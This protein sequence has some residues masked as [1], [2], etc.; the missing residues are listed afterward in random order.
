MPGTPTSHADVHGIHHAFLKDRIPA[1][2][3]QASPRRQQ[4]LGQ[5]GLQLPAWF[6]EATPA[7]RQALAARHD[8]YRG[9]LNRIE[10]TLGAIEDIAAFAEPL[11]K[12]AIKQ[13]F[14]LEL[15]VKQ[16]YFARKFTTRAHS[17]VSA[18]LDADQASGGANDFYRGFSLLETALANFEPDEE[19]ALPCADCQI[20]TGWGSYT[21]EAMPSFE[22]LADERVAIAPHE[23]AQLCRTLDLG[24]RYQAHI[25]ELVQPADG[26]ARTALEQALEQHDREQL[27]LSL[28]VAELQSAVSPSARSMLEQLLVDPAAATLDGR[29]VTLGALKVFGSVLVGPLLI[30]PQRLRSDRVERLVVYLPNDPQQPLKEYVSSAAFMADLRSRLHSASYRQFFSQFVPVREQG[31]FFRRFNRLYQ[32]AG[33]AD[34]ARDYPLQA[35]APR[36]PLDEFTI[37]D[38]LWARARQA[39]VR[40]ICDDARA[41]AVPTG[42]EDRQARLERVMGFFDAVVS[43]FNLAAFVV[44]GLGPL[45]LTVGAA[46]LCDDAFEGIEAFEQGETQEM[47]AHFSSVALNVAAVGT[48]AKVLPQVRLSSLVDGLQPVTLASG[49]QKLWRDDLR[50]YQASV[51]LPADAQPDAQGLYTHEGQRVLVLEGA[52]YRVSQE[53]VGGGYRIRHPSRA[54][55]YE[56]ALVH[57]GQ[58]TWR[59][60]LEQPLTWQGAL[61]MRRLG[62]IV[63][64]FSDVELEQV[65]QVSGIDET[66]LRRLHVDSEPVPP[67]LLD[68]LRQFRAYNSA[69]QVAQGIGEG[70]LPDALCGYAAALAVELP[71]WPAGVAIEA[72]ELNGPSVKYGAGPTPGGA[73]LTISRSELMTGQLP[74]R[75]VEFLGE[76]Q[77]EQLLGRYAPRDTQ[78]RISAVRTQLQT[79]ANLVRARLMRSLYVDQQPAADAAVRVVQRDFASLPTLMVRE[80][81]D[82]ASAAER[83]A[84]AQRGRVPL[85][86]AEQARRLQQQVRLAHAYE[87]LYL[88]ALANRDTEA[89]VLNTMPNLPG[90]ADNLR[91]EVRDGGLEGELRASYGLASARDKKVLVRVGE[92]RYQAFDDRGQQLHGINGLYSALQHALPDAHRN[93]I[94][95]P[96][97]GQGEQLQALI[98]DNALPRDQMRTVLGMRTQ[99][100]PFLRWPQRLSGHRLGYPLSGRGLG[101]GAWRQV[102]E[103]RVR[104]LY[105]S[106]NELQMEDYLRGR[107]LV[108]DQ[109]LQ[110][111][112]MEYKQLDSVLNRWLL[113]GPRDH[114]SLRLRRKIY[115]TLRDI[116]RKS[117]D[118][119]TDFLG[120]Y[121]GQRIYLEDQALG[122]QLATLPPLPGNF[123]HVSSI[124]LPACGLTDQGAGFLLNFRVL[125]ILNLEG[126]QLTRLP[127]VCASMPRMEGLDLSDNE[128][129]LTA[130]TAVH[131]RNMRRLE[132]LALQGNPLSRNLDVSR[133]PRL[134]WL[135]LSGCDLHEW[136]TGLFASPRPRAFLLELTGN[137]LNGIPEVAPGSDRARLLARTAV[138]RDWLAPQV[139]DRLNLYIESVGLDPDRRFPPRG[140]QDS[141]HWMSGLPHSQWLAK[142]EVWN[143][144]EEALGSERFFDELR[145]LSQNLEHR[146]DEYKLDLTA[147]VWRM[148]E[149]MAG[150]TALRERLFEMAVAPTTCVD[151]GA[152]LFNAMGVEVLLHEA[153]SLPNADLMRL[154]LLALAK[155]KARLDELGRIA[156]ARVSELHDQGRRFPEYDAQ[157]DLVQQ[158]DADGNPVSSIDEVEIHMAYV[159]RLADRLDLPWQTGMLYNEPDVTPAMLEAAYNRVIALERGD[160]LRDGIIEQPFWT[161]YVQVTYANEFDAVSAKNEAL[162]NLYSAQQEL[163]D[164][165]NLPAEKKAGL[166]LTIDTSAQVLGKSPGQANPERLMSDEEYFAEVASLGDERKNVLRSV[167]DRVMGRTPQN[168]K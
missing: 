35:H 112:E 88:D 57:N 130:Q 65:R 108:D 26:V 29:P 36:L 118:W 32:P 132:W 141:A 40:K 83:Q 84:L 8:Q 70:Q 92:G 143:D 162:I 17:D 28:Q 21:D 122:A 81:L 45:M 43:V 54:G 16:V 126:N 59:H 102:I 67:I 138:T 153:L 72:S 134:R 24:A 73:T 82:G 113:E 7:A 56:P 124:Y 165:G 149:A 1:W 75:I 71:G 2:Y 156:H 135:Y 55:A 79:R 25:T 161:D 31:E 11:L 127:D 116:W 148:L 111:L 50:P 89:L 101:R 163:A 137:R 37:S 76:A 63:D 104:T 27:T 47:W 38:N 115:E 168:R 91:L 160:L 20:I 117:G 74:R 110:A 22:V 15:D 114:A 6:R 62:P 78:A 86:L 10:T 68:T 58:G 51:A 166:H 140:A 13:R 46:Q 154:E 4:E 98:R 33:Q 121:R 139:R 23:F 152:Q 105:P 39:R 100:P 60:A 61:L 136:P 9:A 49:K 93:A 96:H 119:D 42:D 151:A 69:V 155:G 95:V 80:L 150:D 53:P 145:K 18:F 128:I 103:E 5:H 146:T 19:H 147:K 12:A 158:V 142:Q 77:L 129:V 30:G 64:G 131:L 97:V 144:L 52:H 167:T 87:G 34:A 157:G 90:W 106:M 48:G 14:N 41:V 107:N 94:G 44:P 85:R 99:R 109:W 120:N 123:D 3:T 159:T 164:D 66:R 125:R 133:M